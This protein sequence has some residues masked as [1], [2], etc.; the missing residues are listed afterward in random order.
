MQGLISDNIFDLPTLKRLDLGG[1]NIWFDDEDY[2]FGNIENAVDLVFLNV[3]SSS[4]ELFGNIDDAWLL[5]ELYMT[6]T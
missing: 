4:I 6:N 5:K 3:T 2:G 1:N